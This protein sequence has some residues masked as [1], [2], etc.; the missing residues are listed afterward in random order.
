MRRI[1]NETSRNWKARL[2][3]SFPTSTGTVDRG[4]FLFPKFPTSRGQKTFFDAKMV[5]NTPL[6]VWVRV[7][8]IGTFVG[9]TTEQVSTELTFY[10][11]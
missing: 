7:S 6:P 4:S 5:Q 3:A 2:W 9:R 1:I 11:S 10:F 8:F